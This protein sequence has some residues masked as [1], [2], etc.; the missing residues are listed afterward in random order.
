MFKA[1]YLALLSFA[2][3]ACSQGVVDDNR[4]TSGSAPVQTESNPHATTD[5]APTD[6]VISADRKV[7]VPK[8][9]ADRYKSVIIGVKNTT[10]GLDL[11][12]EVLVGQKADIQGTPYSI[13]VEH[14]LPEFVIDGQGVYT[15]RSAEENNP[16]VKIK[17]FEAGEEVFNGMLYK[18]FP[19]MHGSFAHPEYE[20]TLIKSVVK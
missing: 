13:L 4:S 3:F 9:I 1:I 15:T 20:L 7:S 6:V 14:Y 11:Q 19:D 16:A 5:E 18:N 8:E 2:I 17:V 12:T 10:A